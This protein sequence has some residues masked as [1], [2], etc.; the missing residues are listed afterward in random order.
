MLRGPWSRDQAVTHSRGSADAAD[1]VIRAPGSDTRQGLMLQQL[2]GMQRGHCSGP[3]VIIQGHVHDVLQECSWTLP[4]AALHFPVTSTAASAGT[5]SRGTGTILRLHQHKT[6][7]TS[8][9][10]AQLS[11]KGG[12]E[13]AKKKQ[14]QREGGKHSATR[15]QGRKRAQVSPAT[16]QAS[17]PAC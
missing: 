5:L 14:A 15:W 7:Q 4:Q 6:L 13:T 8:L 10:I 17:P 16:S 11:G 3:G 12:R 9:C 1:A 2:T